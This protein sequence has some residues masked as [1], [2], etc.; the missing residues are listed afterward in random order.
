MP[1][2]DAIGVCDVVLKPVH[3]TDI[4]AAVP[5]CLDPHAGAR[6]LIRLAR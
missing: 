3:E 5:E 6:S 4:L 1:E 2:L